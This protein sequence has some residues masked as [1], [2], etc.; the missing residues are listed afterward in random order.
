MGFTS[1]SDFS[2]PN[3]SSCHVTSHETKAWNF[4]RREKNSLIFV[5]YATIV[6]GETVEKCNPD[7]DGEENI[8]YLCGSSYEAPITPGEMVFNVTVSISKRIKKN[9]EKNRE[10][11]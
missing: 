7:V 5:R 1:R 11:F 8:W 4:D 6:F 3:Y 10:F 9:E 2:W